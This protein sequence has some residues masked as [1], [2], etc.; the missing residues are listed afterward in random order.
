MLNRHALCKF[1]FGTAAFLLAC[2][3]YAASLVVAGVRKTVCTVTINSSEEKDTFVRH[4]PRSECRVVELVRRG[5]PNWLESARRSA[6]IRD[7]LLISG[8]FDNRDGHC[9]WPRWCR[10]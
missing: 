4:L 6:V 5:Q 1:L 2:D 10:R 8:H 9:F 3:A 7:A